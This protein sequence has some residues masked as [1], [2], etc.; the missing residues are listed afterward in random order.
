MASR[1]LTLIGIVALMLALPACTRSA[2]TPPP[3]AG[4]T[5][6]AGVIQPL[7]PNTTD[8]PLAILA[9]GA[10]QTAMATAGIVLPTPTLPGGSPVATQGGVVLPTATPI[11]VGTPVPTFVYTP[12]P[13]PAEYTLK[14]GEFPYCIARRYNLNPQ[15]LLDLNGISTSS[16]SLYQPGLTLKIPQSSLTFPGETALIPHPATY[17][18]LSGDTVYSVACKYGDPDP[19]AIAAANGLQS[20][21]TLTVGRTIQV[22]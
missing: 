10:T 16:G 17:T 9:Q 4:G 14:A 2:S 21:Y 8:D 12:A 18:V 19:L 22:P 1:K 3:G 13:K 5:G 15:E 7:T 6:T 20:P 11:G